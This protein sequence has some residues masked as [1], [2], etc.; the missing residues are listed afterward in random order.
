[1]ANKNS[2]N[3]N[4][5]LRDTRKF[6]KDD[7]KVALEDLEEYKQG[8][9]SID[10]KATVNQQWWMLRHWQVLEERN[11]GVNAGTSV[12]SAWAVNSIINKHAD[13]MDSFPAP[14]ILPR[15]ADDQAEAEAL[16][17]VIPAILAQND[18]EEVYRDMSWDFAIDG[19]N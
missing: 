4:F 5:I 8:K 17:D 2:N 9:A 13:M 10:Q 1:M 12:G 7:A 14:N 6:T 19:A 16:T 15:E 11:E 3:E 18:Y